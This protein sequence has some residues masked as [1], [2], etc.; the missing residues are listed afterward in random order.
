MNNST[1]NSVIP[2]FNKQIDETVARLQAQGLIIKTI[3]D[4]H[5]IEDS[6]ESSLDVS[7]KL[8]NLIDEGEDYF[9]EIPKKNFPQNKW[10]RFTDG[11]IFFMFLGNVS[12]QNAGKKAKDYGIEDLQIVPIEYEGDSES[13]VLTEFSTAVW[14]QEMIDKVNR[15]AKEMFQ[16]LKQGKLAADDDENDNVNQQ[17]DAPRPVLDTSKPRTVTVKKHDDQKEG[18]ED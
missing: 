3:F 8:V 18:N 6:T 5:I 7:A 4:C 17:S 2:S 10:T 11:T 15:D 1:T 12:N 14:T 13:F 16:F 9:A